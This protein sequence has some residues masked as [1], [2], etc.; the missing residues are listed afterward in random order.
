MAARN[1]G[2]VGRERRALDEHGLVGLVG[3]GVLDDPLGAAGVAD[4]GLLLREL[5]VPTL[6]PTKKART[7]NAIQPKTAILRC[8]ALQRPTRAAMLRFGLDID[9]SSGCGE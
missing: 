2:I 3:V 8:R 4:A 6:P 9:L 5:L 1:C 7:T